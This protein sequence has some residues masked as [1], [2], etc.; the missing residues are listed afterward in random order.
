VKRTPFFLALLLVP[1]LTV[2]FLGKQNFK[3]YLPAALF[4]C[5]FTKVLD[6]T[7][8][9]R[10]WWRYYKGI[11]PIDS[12]NFFNFGP[13]LVISMWFLR[14]TYGKFPL[15]LILN[16]ISHVVYIFIAEK[17]LKRYKIGRL[18]KMKLPTYFGLLSLRGLVLYG[19]QMLIDWPKNKN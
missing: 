11:G 19:F 10:K 8:Q 15:Y 12:M 14:M 7:G 9:R 17:P 16:T 13:Y 1:W 5:F 6:M 2:P 4:S 3:K 18:V